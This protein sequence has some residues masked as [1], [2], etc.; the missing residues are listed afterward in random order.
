MDD[1]ILHSFSSPS[2][3]ESG[4]PSRHGVQPHTV[5]LC[6]TRNR[7][8]PAA[9]PCSLPPSGGI[10]TVS[11][12]VQGRPLLCITAVVTAVY[13]HFPEERAQFARTVRRSL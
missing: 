1:I 12:A 2:E 6:L 9:F 10:A 3:T 4:F 7:W 13:K 5:L 11:S 8:R